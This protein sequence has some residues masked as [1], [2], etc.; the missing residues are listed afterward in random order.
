MICWECG[1]T[2]I[3]AGGVVGG[4]STVQCEDC[5]ATRTE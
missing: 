1:S 3:R 5:G 2:N 4:A